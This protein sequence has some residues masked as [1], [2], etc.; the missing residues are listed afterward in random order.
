[1]HRVVLFSQLFATALQLARAERA[2]EDGCMRIDLVV[3]LALVA[4]LQVEPLYP[5]E[6]GACA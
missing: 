5:C 3:D 1:M 4:R 2:R 6:P